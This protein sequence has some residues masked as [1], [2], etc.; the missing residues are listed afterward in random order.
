MSCSRARPWARRTAAGPGFD[1]R[2]TD[3]AALLLAAR[4]LARKLVAVLV[5]AQRTQQIV[6][7]ERVFGQVR[8]DLDVFLDG[9][10]GHQVVEL[11][12]KAQLAASVLAQ[13][14]GL[15]RREIAAVHHD[16]AAVASSRPPI[17]LR[18]V[19]LPEPEGPSMTQISPRLMDVSMPSST[20]R[21]AS[22]SP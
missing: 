1:E 20:V 14:G 12:D 11:E 4:D 22:P 13:I 9:K 7:I 10:V 19:D 18:K 3:G 2:T 16:G 17:R 5:E 6:D 21:R 15:E 8:R